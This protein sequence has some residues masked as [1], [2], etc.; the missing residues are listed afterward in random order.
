VPAAAVEDFESLRRD[1]ARPDA[2]VIGDLDAE[3]DFDTLNRA[4][5]R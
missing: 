4:F 3:W 5:R 2:V 1:E